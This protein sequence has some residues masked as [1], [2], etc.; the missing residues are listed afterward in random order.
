MGEDKAFLPFKKSNTLLEY[1]YNRLT[2]IFSNVFISLKNDIKNYKGNI[3]FDKSQDIYSPMIALDS[4]FES[5]QNKQIFIITID[6]PFVSQKT[7]ENLITNS[8]DYEVTIAKT[9]NNKIHYLCGVFCKDLKEQ[10]EKFINQDM[11]QIKK[12]IEKSKVF[13]LD[14]M[15]SEEFFNINTQEDYCKAKKLMI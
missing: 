3:I 7:I 14:V 13:I 11:H 1:Q 9:S 15:N 2:K 10:T 5:I 8:K 12:L 6:T 4:I